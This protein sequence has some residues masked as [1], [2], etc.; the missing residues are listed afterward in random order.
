MCVCVLHF[1][2]AGAAA[3]QRGMDSNNDKHAVTKGR[4]EDPPTIHILNPAILSR[5]G[6][7]NTFSDHLV[8]ASAIV[9]DVDSTLRVHTAFD[10]SHDLISSDVINDSGSAPSIIQNCL[11]QAPS[12]IRRSVSSRGGHRKSHVR[13]LSSVAKDYVAAAQ[14]RTDSRSGS[15]QPLEST[16][17]LPVNASHSSAGNVAIV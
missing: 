4:P 14:G 17:V 5:T 2:A 1:H 12:Q 8:S 10:R 13:A 9:V 15:I 7:D 6:D 3:E 16:A 11:M